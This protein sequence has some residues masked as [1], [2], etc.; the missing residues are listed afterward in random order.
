M[1]TVGSLFAGIG[2]FDLGLENAGGFKI[3]WQVEMDNH[4]NRVLEK[5][6]PEVRRWRDVRTFPPEP[7][8]DWRVDIITGGDPC[9][10][11]GNARRGQKSAHPDLAGYFLAVVG[12][13][14]PRWVLRENVPAPTVQDFDGA[15]AALGYGTVIV[16][17]DAAPFTAQRRI[18]DFIVGCHNADR[19][20][21]AESFSECSNDPGPHQARLA[22]ASISACLTTNRSRHN[23]DEN[24]IYEQ[25]RGIRILD[26]QERERLAGFPVGWTDGLSHSAVARVS[27]NAVVP[28]VVEWIAKRIKNGNS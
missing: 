22:L 21:L 26:D 24:Y 1:I 12:R 3:A 7:V 10:K 13:L 15:L 16:R 28:Q 9:P 20:I 14:R 6:W 8:N 27:G 18:R 5:H 17:M 23:T 2:G 11:H 4:A 19:R 25:G